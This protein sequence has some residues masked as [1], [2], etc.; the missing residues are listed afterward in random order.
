MRKRFFTLYIFLI[1]LLCVAHSK[2]DVWY[3]KHKR[4]QTSNE[5]DILIF[6]QRWPLTACFVWKENSA[7]HTCSLPKHDEWTIHGIWPTKYHTL[8]PQY[9][10]KSLPFNTDAIAP[11]ESQLKENWL[12]IQN[13]SDPYAFWKHEWNKHGTC[14]ISVK[15]ISNEFDY[16]KE[17]LDLLQTYNMIDVLAK[18][19]V[20]PGEKYAVDQIMAAVEKILGKTSQVMCAKDRKTGESYVLEIR[21]CFDKTLRL[22]DCN[23]VYEF[24]TN[25]DRTEPIIYPSYVPHRYSVQQT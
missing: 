12:D 3:K 25:C 24:P 5:F 1:S 2:N 4:R 14:A 23:G 10:N 7:D 19:N 16:F 22:T 8:G 21:I 20:L 17:G 15:G 18:A 9:C 11:L 6:T 13:G